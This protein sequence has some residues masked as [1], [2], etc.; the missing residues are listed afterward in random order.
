MGD[1][2]Y[3][4][5]CAG[6]LWAFDKASG[7]VRWRYDTAADA[8]GAQFHGDPVVVG[9][10]LV[11]PS[12][13]RPAGY[14]YAFER[15]TGEVRWK[16]PV[17]PGGV[18]SHLRLAGDVVLGTTPTGRLTAFDLATG[19]ERWS[20]EPDAGVEGAR[21]GNHPASAGGRVFYGS[22]PTAV[23]AVDTASGAI[24]WTRDLGGRPNTAAV[25]DG[26]HL[27]VGTADRR[28][29]RLRQADGEVVARLELPA[30]PVG[31][32]VLADGRLVL[33]GAGGLIAAVDPA[34][35]AIVW[36]YTDPSGWSSFQPLVDGDTV[37]AGT[38]DGELYAF[39]LESG[40]VR[41][42][43]ELAGTPRGIGGEGGVYYV[44]TLQ[45]DLYAFAP[46]EGDSGADPLPWLAGSWRGESGETV[47]EETWSELEGD[48]RMGMFRMV[49]GGTVLFYEFMTI[50]R[51]DDGGWALRIKHF[52]RGLVGW[53]ER[54]DSEV[55][56]LTV[57]EPRRAVFVGR[58]AEVPK[59]LIYTLDEAGELLVELVK[60]TPEGTT[61]SEFRFRRR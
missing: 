55:F 37:V 21:M 51:R 19:A 41:W 2:V 25:L 4:A 39:D 26:E 6:S 11:I 61:A 44:G 46:G 36:Q 22:S 38:D 43:E 49:A 52:D 8:T 34:L 7:E 35:D 27:L 57:A 14:V 47:I 17:A 56:D 1:L 32:P 12:D 13:A 20:V 18:T 54:Q 29:H 3:G 10:L 28:L 40:A 59:R 5:S 9:D 30:R 23:R 16:T 50:E 58:D 33:V 48:N 15:A 60:E 42:K 31:T 24:V 45:G 53:E